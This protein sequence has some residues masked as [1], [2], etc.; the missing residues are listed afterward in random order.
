MLDL[1]DAE[2]TFI[3]LGMKTFT[4]TIQIQYNATQIH[5]KI[6]TKY[7]TKSIQIHY[8]LKKNT[9][10]NQHKIQTYVVYQALSP[11]IRSPTTLGG[12]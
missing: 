8:K 11:K 1:L 12:F 9:K 6:N 4:N 2:R 10:Q 7:K 3:T 5:Y